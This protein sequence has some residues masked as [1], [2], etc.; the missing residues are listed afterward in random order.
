MKLE[1][2]ASRTR[3]ATPEEAGLPALRLDDD[4]HAGGLV[5]W[6]GADRSRAAVRLV[7]RGEDAG[8]LERERLYER[9]AGR[10]LGWGDSVHAGLPGTPGGWQPLEL[11]CPV[12]GCPAPPQWVLSY[13]PADAPP[14]SVHPDAKLRPRQ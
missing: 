9:V 5:A 10:T 14:C 1:E 2:L 12:A 11:E 4:A 6:F 7:I 13:D 3:A 8:V